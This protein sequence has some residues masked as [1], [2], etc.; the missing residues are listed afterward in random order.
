MK[1]ARQ[2]LERLR[3]I[4]ELDRRRAPAE[5]LLAELRKLVRDGEAWLR[6]EGEPAAAAQ[7]LERCGIALE[8]DGERD[9]GRDGVALLAR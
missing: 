2:V 3:R 6:A 4:E 8:G 5:E 9:A 1:E 7:A